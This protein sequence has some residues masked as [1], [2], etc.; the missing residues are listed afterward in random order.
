M[1][2]ICIGNE[3]ETGFN[4][5]LKIGKIYEIEMWRDTGRCSVTDDSGRMHYA[6]VYWFKP[7]DQ[8]RQEQINKV[9]E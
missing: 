3:D 2:A 9:L 8:Y 7:I 4:S 6:P 5:Y 1:K